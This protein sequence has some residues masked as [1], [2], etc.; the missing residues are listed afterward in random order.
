MKSLSPVHTHGKPISPDAMAR[1]FDA[2]VRT[3]EGENA[4]LPSNNLGLGLYITREIVSAHGGTIKVT[5][6]ERDGTAFTARLPLW[7]KGTKTRNAFGPH[8]YCA[9][10]VVDGFSTSHTR[11]VEKDRTRAIELS[12]GVSRT[13]GPT[14]ALPAVVRRQSE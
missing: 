10:N 11:R 12:S 4:L 14:S 5:S 9:R 6:S 7:T 13:P 2:L 1:I 8:L 3:V